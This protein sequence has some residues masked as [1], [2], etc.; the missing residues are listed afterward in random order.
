[1]GERWGLRG[2]RPRAREM[3][4]LDPHERVL[5]DATRLLARSLK[6]ASP[7]AKHPGKT[8]E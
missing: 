6:A 7:D 2:P 1:M 8:E 5:L 4:S 3:I